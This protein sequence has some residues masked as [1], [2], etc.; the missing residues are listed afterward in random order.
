MRKVRNR[1]MMITAPKG[2]G[3][4]LRRIAVVSPGAMTSP[5]NAAGKEILSLRY[6]L[7]TIWF[8]VIE[9]HVITP[10]S[11]HTNLCVVI[12]LFGVTYEQYT[13]F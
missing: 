13:A 9:S 2:G 4:F 10:T 6:L 3:F 11:S 7:L 8:R 12:P 1:V 5:R